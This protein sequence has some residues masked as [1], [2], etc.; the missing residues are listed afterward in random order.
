MKYIYILKG[1]NNIWVYSILDVATSWN[2]IVDLALKEVEKYPDFE[3]ESLKNSQIPN[4]TGLI[5]EKWDPKDN[6]MIDSWN[7][8]KR[9]KSEYVFC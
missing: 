7:L 6:E 9:H 1:D 4:F 5:I 8:Y 3:A 2:K